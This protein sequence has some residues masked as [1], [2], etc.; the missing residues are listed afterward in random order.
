MLKLLQSQAVFLAY[1]TELHAHCRCGIF[2]SPRCHLIAR[3][4]RS[5]ALCFSFFNNGPNVCWNEA[6]PWAWLLIA[7]IQV[8]ISIHHRV[9][10]R[11]EAQSH[12]RRVVLASQTPSTGLIE[13][14]SDVQVLDQWQ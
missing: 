12:R 2:S 4:P 3:N 5:N 10:S 11:Q 14:G 1:L 6:S 8:S 7:S 9:L 13:F